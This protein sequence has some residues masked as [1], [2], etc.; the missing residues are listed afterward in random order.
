MLIA[1]AIHLQV[2]DFPLGRCTTCFHVHKWSHLLVNHLYCCKSVT[3]VG[4]VL[5]VGFGA[6][7]SAAMI[8]Q[9]VESWRSSKSLEQ[10]HHSALPH[11]VPHGV[12]LYPYSVEESSNG[13]R[14]A[15]HVQ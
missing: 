12:L 1:P 3:E 15:V 9:H 7:W 10:N 5:T 8:L 6:F 2:K 14:N 11:S 4:T 13:N